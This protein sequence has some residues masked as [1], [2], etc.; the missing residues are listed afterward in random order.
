MHPDTA[1]RVR[2][3]WALI[4]PQRKTVCCDFYRR[5]FGLFPELRPLF[6]GEIS[7]QADLFV[8]MINTVISA[9]E[10]PERV[11]PLIEILGARHAD[12]G[13][14]PEDYAKFER[15]LIETLGDA[16]G[17]ELDAEGL[18]AWREVFETLAQTMQAGAAH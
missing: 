6:K 14:Q 17:D 1:S 3:S 2:Q 8:T 12:Y 16:L 11:R 5:L 7:E 18:A 13:V 4:L 15:V 9:L 10:H